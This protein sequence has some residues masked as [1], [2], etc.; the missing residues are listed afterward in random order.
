MKFLKK[1]RFCFDKIL[2]VLYGT[3]Y[4][5]YRQNVIR[6][7]HARWRF[8]QF[9]GPS[10]IVKIKQHLAATIFYIINIMQYDCLRKKSFTW[11][12]CY[13]FQLLGRD[14]KVQ[15]KLIKKPILKSKIAKQV[16]DRNWQN[17]FTSSNQ[18]LRSKALSFQWIFLPN[19]HFKA[20]RQKG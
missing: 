10:D 19:L 17:S 13:F 5:I 20:W 15:V 1:S 8:L 9:L 11:M 12:R 6:P 18:S 7:L 3:M 14:K 16:K 4:D 2:S